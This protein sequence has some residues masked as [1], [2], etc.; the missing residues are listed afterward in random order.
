MKIADS[1]GMTLIELL[2]A[3]MAF[4]LLVMALVSLASEGLDTWTEGEGRKDVYERAQAILDMVAEDVRNAYAENEWR[5]SGRERLQPPAFVCDLDSSKRPRLRLVRTGNPND[6]KVDPEG[7]LDAR[8][9]AVQYTDA[10]EIAYVMDP[11]PAVNALYRG[12]RYFDRDRR[13]SLFDNGVAALMGV[14]LQSDH[15]CPRCGKPAGSGP[16]APGLRHFSLV[17]DGVL[18]LGFKFWTQFTNTWDDGVRTITQRRRGSQ[19]SGPQI[20]WDSTRADVTR[21]VFHRRVV[22]L[23]DPDFAYPEIAQVS[24]TLESTS[25]DFRGVELTQSIDGKALRIPVGTTKGMPDA[26]NFAKVGEEWIEYAD[27]LAGE[28]V[29]KRRGV[30]GTKGEAH[31]AG[32]RLHFGRNFVTD[33]YVPVHREVVNP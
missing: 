5:T 32:D 11:C 28:V 9:P 21:F 30:R 14:T 33:V 10:W 20:F 25:R 13:G 12:V 16:P 1:R 27:L 23:E 2:V 3:F 7:R 18:Y 24:L 15:S 6:I 22:H 17:D 29:V 19:P 26:P 31:P 4:L 8:I